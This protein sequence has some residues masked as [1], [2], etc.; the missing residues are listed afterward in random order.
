MTGELFINSKDAYT[1]W[2]ISMDDTSLS[3]LMAPPPL[4][5]F[6]EDTSRLE[7]GKRVDTS[8]PKMDERNITLQINLTA[9]DKDEFF[10]RYTSFCE[11]LA[12]GVLEIRTKYQPTVLY[13]TTYLSCSQFSQFIQGIGKFTLKLNEPDPSRR[14]I[15]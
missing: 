14:N 4:K 9:R 2:G 10:S 6:I 13:R 1:T 15:T 12:T 8:N 5:E 11:E 3:S 7:H